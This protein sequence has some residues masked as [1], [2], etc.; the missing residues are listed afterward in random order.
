MIILLYVGEAIALLRMFKGKFHMNHC[1]MNLLSTF[2]DGPC[3]VQI[4]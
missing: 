4:T 1:K 3:V 2:E